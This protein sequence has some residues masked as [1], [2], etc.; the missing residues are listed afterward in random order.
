MREESPKIRQPRDIA[1]LAEFF[2]E[3]GLPV[4][5]PGLPRRRRRPHLGACRAR[6]SDQCRRRSPR[7]MPPTRRDRTSTKRY[8]PMR[9][10]TESV[11]AIADFEAPAGSE[12]PSTNRFARPH[13]L[14]RRRSPSFRFG[15]RRRRPSRCPHSRRPG[16][17]RRPH[18]AHS[19]FDWREAVA[20]I[21]QICLYSER[22]FAELA[23]PARP[24]HHSNQRQG[25]SASAVRANQQ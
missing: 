4:R 5:S 14:A 20:V 17:A 21:H 11:R 2:S 3:I 15:R 13:I 9:T 12:R 18:R 19:G 24:A 22:Q 10:P 6:Q 16:H 23:D 25:R 8:T 1:E 7:A